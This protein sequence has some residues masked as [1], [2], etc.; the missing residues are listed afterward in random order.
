MNNAG[1]TALVCVGVASGI[2]AAKAQQSQVKMEGLTRKIIA[3]QVAIPH[4]VSGGAAGRLD[5]HA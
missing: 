3:E 1:L 2:L 4:R 5:R